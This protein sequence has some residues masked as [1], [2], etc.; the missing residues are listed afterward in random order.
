MT[1]LHLPSQLEVTITET[2]VESFVGELTKRWPRF[3]VASDTGPRDYRQDPFEI[4]QIGIFPG[5]SRAGLMRKIS[6]YYH[7]YRR[8]TGR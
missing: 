7:R 4:R 8:I 6:E 1:I 3:L 2:H 5:L